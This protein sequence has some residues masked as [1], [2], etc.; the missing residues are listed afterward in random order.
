MKFRY[1]SFPA[2]SI[3]LFFL[4]LTDVVAAA[5]LTITQRVALLETKVTNLQSQ[6][7][8]NTAA[9]TA[10]ETQVATLQASL[11]ENVPFTGAFFVK[12][13]A[14]DT[15]TAS[16]MALHSDGTITNTG[17]NMFCVAEPGC[18]GLTPPPHGTWKKT[19][20]NQIAVTWIQ[21]VTDD[22]VGG[23]FGASGK[24]FKLTWV[25]SFDTLQGGVFQHWA[26]AAYTANVYNNNQ[27]PI[28]D[29]PVFV[30]EV[31]DSPFGGQRI[32]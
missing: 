23:D 19:G 30:G 10:L 6:L 20:E 16:V 13:G 17:P 7:T 1:L 32:N 11:A 12:N 5:P 18:G 22:L 3:L 15:R 26:V 29:V 25:Q 9:D 21:L 4:P 2:L 31:S 27:N 8:A 28:T 24:I 14:G